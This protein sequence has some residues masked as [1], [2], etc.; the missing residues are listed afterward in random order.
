MSS[1]KSKFDSD[2]RGPF[3]VSLTLLSFTLDEAYGNRIACI[4]D[5]F[6]VARSVVAEHGYDDWSPEQQLEAILAVYDK[7]VETDRIWNPKPEEEDG[8]D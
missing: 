7:M 2:G 4:G 8:E 6:Y 5:L 1:A 3:G